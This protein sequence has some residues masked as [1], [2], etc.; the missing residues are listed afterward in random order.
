MP[1]K[2]KVFVGREG[3]EK[4]R[5]QELESNRE[6]TKAREQNVDRVSTTR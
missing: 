2:E 4:K 1:R 6:A 3:N 5:N